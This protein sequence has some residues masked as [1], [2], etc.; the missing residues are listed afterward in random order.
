MITTQCYGNN[1]DSGELFPEELNV[2]LV[3]I[4]NPLL[5]EMSRLLVPLLLKEMEGHKGGELVLYL[6]LWN[7][8][9]EI[10]TPRPLDS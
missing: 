6:K 1:G 3:F 4:A 7:V 10:R 2:V 8:L 5:R 9:A